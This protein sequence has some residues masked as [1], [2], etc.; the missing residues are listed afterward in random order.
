MKKGL[1][2]EIVREISKLKDEPQWMTDFRLNAYHLFLQKQLPGWGPDLSRK[3]DFDDYYYYVSPT[4]SK[5]KEADWSKVPKNI[6]DTFDKL[7][8]PEAERKYLAGSAAQLESDVVYCNLKKEWESKGII[9]CDM[10]TA[11]KEHGE[12][13]KEYIGKLVPSSD[14][15]FAALNSAVWSG[16]SFIYIPRGVK[17]DIPLQAYFRINTK[18]IGQ[19]ERTLIIAD[20]ESSV[21]YIEGC[22]APIY[23][24]SALHAAVVEVFAK[25][26]AK[27]RYT[28]IQNWSNNVLNLVTKRS[29]AEENAIIE[30][31]D[32]NIGSAVTMKYPCVILRGKGAK[33]NILSVAYSGKGQIQDAGAKVFHLAPNTS[34]KII[35]KSLSKDGGRS[36]YRGLVKIA[37]GAK[38]AKCSVK[39]DALILDEK[40]RSDT[41]PTIDIDEKSASV[42]HEAS[43]GKISADKLFYIQSRG[44][45]ADDA[46]TVV[47]LG[48][49][50]PFVKELP[51]E[52]AVELNRL[53]RMSM[54]GAVG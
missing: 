30:W 46:M 43:V 50:E 29:V 24:E 53:I 23:S 5:S 45:K 38:G 27:V 32:G 40:S 48:F 35:S 54:E 1:T 14:N 10:D 25:R 11:V 47:V 8:I 39:C 33:T 22:S 37:K 52:Y 6:R 3:I 12:I 21:S 7:G 31:V 42:S 9:F 26:G 20:E 15:T 2:E 19:F 51:M 34:S 13:V 41:Y 4:D 36:S 17:L 16:G 28:T 44:I 49:V 18:N